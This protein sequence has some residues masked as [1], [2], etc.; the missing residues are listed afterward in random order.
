VRRLILCLLLLVQA[1]T[2]SAQYEDG[3]IRLAVPAGFEGPEVQSN[4][5]GWKI[6][7]RPSR[8]VAGE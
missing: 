7:R 8:G 6:G 4:A 1:A 3:P 5:P 2:L